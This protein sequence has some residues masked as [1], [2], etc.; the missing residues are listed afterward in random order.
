MSQLT[1]D[2]IELLRKTNRVVV[3]RPEHVLPMLNAFTRK[4]QEHFGIILLN[5]GNEVIAKKVLFIGGTNL[6]HIDIKMIFWEACCKK[7]SGL[8]IFHNHPGGSL[9]PSTLDI[10]LTESINKAC[11]V[12]GI[13]LLD[14]IIL[15]KY[16]YYSFK[17]H[18][19][20]FGNDSESKAAEV[21]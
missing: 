6:T 20:V 7:A 3:K 2:H 10:E 14:H 21:Q 1:Q 16:G 18:D 5:S 15:S 17:E 4:K 19:V 11:G 12:I 9:N 8:I 13:Q